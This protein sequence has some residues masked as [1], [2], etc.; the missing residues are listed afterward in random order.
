M[1]KE[2]KSDYESALERV[3]SLP[4]FYLGQEVETKDGRGIIVS[5]QMRYDKYDV[6]TDFSS[7]TVWFSTEKAK[8]HGRWVN[9]LYLLEHLK[10]V[11]K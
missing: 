9:A 7:A 5:L 11:D 8:E 4:K 10:P 6:D 3:S 1:E 2:K